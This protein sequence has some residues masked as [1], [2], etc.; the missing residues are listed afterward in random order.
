MKQEKTVAIAIFP[1]ISAIIKNVNIPDDAAAE[2]LRAFVDSIL[3][4]EEVKYIIE[5]STDTHIFVL[6]Y[7]G[8]TPSIAKRK[9]FLYFSKKEFWKKNDCSAADW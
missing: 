4:Y 8:R 5:D 9:E 7:S 1:F 3:P 2:N 6:L